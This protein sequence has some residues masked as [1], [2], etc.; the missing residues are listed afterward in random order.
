[1][2]TVNPQDLPIDRAEA[3]RYLGYKPGKRKIGG[4][5]LRLL[6][7]EIEKARTLINPRGLYKIVEVGNLKDHKFFSDAQKVVFGVA[8]VGE[9]L[10]KEVKRLFKSGE[11]TRGVLLDAVGSVCAEAITDLVNAEAEEWASKNGL[12]ITRRFSPGYSGWNV[13]E[14]KL[15]FDYLGKFT[16][17]VKL[18]TSGIMVPLKSVS[19]ACKLSSE[20][21]V[22]INKGDKCASC[23]MRGRCAFSAEEGVCRKTAKEA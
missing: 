2:L 16:A 7:E 14:Q 5:I 12:N 11:G 3:L 15:V 23:N 8:T 9:K 19:F 13:R 17:G 6:D 4:K 21:M 18:T 10:E 22:E 20:K 1:M